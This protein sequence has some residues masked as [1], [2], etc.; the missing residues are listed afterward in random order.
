MTLV[1]EDACPNAIVK[2][3]DA[4]HL[5][6]ET[7]VK[8]PLLDVDDCDLIID[9]LDEE[10]IDLVSVP[11]RLRVYTQGSFDHF[12]GIYA[13]I[14]AL[15]I[16]KHKCNKGLYV[17]WSKVFAAIIRHV[18]SEDLLRKV[19]L[20][21]LTRAEHQSCLKAAADYLEHRHDLSVSWS[22]PWLGRRSMS[23]RRMVADLRQHLDQ[24]CTS[25]I[26]HFIHWGQTHWTALETVSNEGLCLADS[27]KTVEIKVND[28]CF[29]KPKAE[30]IFDDYNLNQHGVLSIT[31]SSYATAS[32]TEAPPV[33]V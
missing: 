2:A 32:E 23:T 16:A 14:N 20:R 13:I 28:L 9:D 30:P 21:G 19:V 25:V 11:L 8:E 27:A 4:E 12:C 6:L 33:Q 26:L 31:M 1:N 24:P 10:F 3:D 17:D 15:R 7:S 22:W 5:T 29:T 18:D